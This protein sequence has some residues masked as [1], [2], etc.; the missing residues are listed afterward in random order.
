MADELTRDFSGQHWSERFNLQKVSWGAIWAGVMVTIGMEALFLSFGIFIAGAFGG[1]EVWSYAWYLVT[2]AISFYT[3]AAAAT[4]LS[5]V[6]ARDVRILHGLAT[7]GLATLS[8][9]LIGGVVAGV[10]GYTA[11]TRMNVQYSG[12]VWGPVERNA[13]IIWGGIMLSF[14]T[15][16]FAGTKTPS[17]HTTEQRSQN[18]TPLPHAH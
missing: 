15:A 10:A 9:V 18:P 14:V 16:Y 8:T 13:G 6:T 3:G 5:D 7:W 2:M 1:S 4:R 11:L 17:Q 12:G